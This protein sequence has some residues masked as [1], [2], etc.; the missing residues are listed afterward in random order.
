MRVSISLL[1]G[2][3]WAVKIV[4]AQITQPARY[5]IEQ[6]QG[7]TS[8]LL[9]SMQEKGLAFLLDKEKIMDR[10]SRWYLVLLDTTLNEAYKKELALESRLKLVGYDF[11]DNDL[12]FLFR[13]GDTNLNNLVLLRIDVKTHQE[14][15]YTITQQIEFRLSHFSMLKNTALFGGYIAN[16]PAV[17]LYDLEQNSQKILPGFFLTDN[18]LLD[19]RVN[20][21]NTFNVLLVDRGNKESKKIVLRTYD[22]Q[23]TQLLEDVVNIPK[24]K[25]IISGITSTLERDE[26]IIVGAWGVDNSKLASGVFTLMVDPFGN[27]SIQF[28]GYNDL[29]H[30][31]DFMNAKRAE[32]IKT[33]E[34]SNKK[35]ERKPGFKNALHIVKMDET[36]KGFTLLAEMY[37]TFATSFSS[38]NPYSPYSSPFFNTPQFF[39]PYSNRYTN[40]AFP[41]YGNRAIGET[42]FHALVI[43][44]DSKGNL[45]K[46]NGLQL[47]KVKLSSLEQVSDFVS[48]PAGIGQVYKKESE[49]IF[50]VT[51]ANDLSTQDTV[52]I[53]LKN[54]TDKV[55][56]EST[57]DGG[58]RSW[59]RNV[60]YTWGYCTLKHTEKSIDPSRNVY[61]INKIRLD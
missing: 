7:A 20:K 61:Y 53:Q 23:G 42:V 33:K 32:K 9:V 40:G 60:L 11:I 44:F 12:H 19:L 13:E 18:E 24:E 59:Y 30:P 50:T 52:K 1:V 28:Y 3:V 26:L 47:E 38:G 55:T 51:E 21:N 10:K 56:F 4:N 16:E 37:S 8:P 46:D 2:L 43:E 14:T 6:K 17:I 41:S 57:E 22:S 31:F 58:I 15:S 27:Q 39:S 5:E 48:I 34:S 45:L 49:L 29:K 54:P 35:N 36:K 25:T